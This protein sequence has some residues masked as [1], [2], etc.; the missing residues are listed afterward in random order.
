MST[1]DVAISSDLGKWGN[2]LTKPDNTV[3]DCN[4]IRSMAD[5]QRYPITPEHRALMVK[6]LVAIVHHGARERERIAAAKAL[7]S[8][9][10]LNIEEERGGSG[11]GVTVNIVNQNAPQYGE[12][13]AL[14][15][16][17]L[18]RIAAI[19]GPG[20]IEAESSPVEPA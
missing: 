20:T 4:L 5:K 7:A 12:L 8:L 16:A 9:D 1:A 11:G 13:A 2:L 15:D 6:R 17:D 10:K 3:S 14:T 18:M 19:G